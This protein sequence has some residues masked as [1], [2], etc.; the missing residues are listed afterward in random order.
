MQQCS[1]YFLCEGTCVLFWG[2]RS[3]QTPIVLLSVLFIVYIFIF[4]SAMPNFFNSFVYTGAETFRNPCTAYLLTSPR[5]A[6][7]QAFMNRI[8]T[9][10]VNDCQGRTGTFLKVKVYERG[11]RLI[12]NITVRVF[13]IN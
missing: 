13:G 11:L 9:R 1:Y 12:L 7:V 6:K 8:L 4:F 3:V 5:G 2:A 10:T